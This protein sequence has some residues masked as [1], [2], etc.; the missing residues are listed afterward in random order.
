M[1]FQINDFVIELNESVVEEFIDEYQN[2]IVNI[3]IDS[4]NI[5]NY[6][7]LR[8]APVISKKVLQISI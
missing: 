1:V 5:Q 4:S 2:S 8:L 3:Q 6:E 7:E